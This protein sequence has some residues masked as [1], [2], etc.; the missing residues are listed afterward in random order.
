M[1]Q[2]HELVLGNLKV[3]HPQRLVGSLSVA[4][5]KCLAGFMCRPR[6]L[7]A[8]A[9]AATLVRSLS[10]VQLFVSPWTVARQAPWGLLG[11]NTGVSCHFL[12]PGIFLDLSPAL[13]T[14]SFPL[15]H[16]GSP[17][18]LLSQIFLN[19]IV[20]LISVF[21]MDGAKGKWASLE[22]SCTVEEARSSITCSHLARWVRWWAETLCLCKSYFKS[23][24][25]IFYIKFAFQE[26]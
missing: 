7:Q 2:A 26:V 15:S 1:H 6:S 9:A 25:T 19:P 16:Q 17:V 18:L 22:A 5:M 21:G 24:I 8:R 20:Q 23:M 3:R 14:D 11:K 13:A 4:S 10:H 12:L